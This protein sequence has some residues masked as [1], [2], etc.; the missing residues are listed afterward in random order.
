MLVEYIKSKSGKKRGVLVADVD[1]E[2]KKVL[3]GFSLCHTTKDSFDVV[4][5]VKRPGFGVRTAYNR[6]I[7]WAHFKDFTIS[8]ESSDKIPPDWRS[9]LVT[10]PQ[11]IAPRVAKFA[12]R[13]RKYFKQAQVPQW[14]EIIETK[15]I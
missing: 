11:S 6:S 14:A 15:F 8:T 10:V 2:N 7:K 12:T 4:D 13:A 1:E 5:G 3:I 9:G